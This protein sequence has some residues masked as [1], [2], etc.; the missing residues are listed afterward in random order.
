MSTLGDCPACG[1]GSRTEVPIAMDLA[2]KG[3]APF[4]HLVR[5]QIATQPITKIPTAQ[6][7][8]G[9]RKTIV[10]SDGRQKAA[11]LARD[12]PREI[13]L[14]VF[15]QILFISAESLRSTNNEPRLNEDIYTAFL[16]CLLSHNLRFFD[17]DDRHHIEQHLKD[18]NSFYDN[19]LS[20]AL[21]DHLQAPPSF[22]S[23]LLKQLGTPFYSISALSLGYVSPCRTASKRLHSEINDLNKD[24]LDA[25]AVIWIQR[26]LAN[27]AFGKDLADGVR[28]KASRYPVRAITAKDGFSK[29]QREFLTKKGVNVDILV[30]RL[31]HN[32]CESKPDGSIY[33]RPSHVILRPALKDR[34]AQCEHCKTI[35]PLPILGHCPNCTHPGIDLV[36]PDATSYL[37]ARKGFWRDPVAQA[38]LGNE[39]PMSIDVQ[40][41][42]AQLSYKDHNTPSPTTEV[43]ERQF[44]DI[45]REGE[46]SI[47]VLSCTT[48]MEVGIDIGSLIAVSMRNVPPMRQNYQQRAGRAGRR[49]AAVS[50]VLTYAQS[51]AHD[52]FYFLNPERMLGGD[53]PRPVLDTENTR[54]A[55]RHLLAQLLQDFF[56]PLA[57]S[58][59]AHDIYSALGDSWNFF[60]EENDPASFSSFKNWVRG[61]H[62]GKD[63]LQRAQNWLPV[64][65][66]S[67]LVAESMLAAIEARTPA[68]REG[69]ESS[70]I[71][72]L[73]AHGLLPSYAFPTDLCSLQ[74]QEKAAGTRSG[75]RVAEQAQQSL[76]V[77]LSEYAPGR[78]VVVNKKTYRV[79]TVTASCPDTEINRAAAL[80][81]RA[82]VYRHCTQCSFTAGFITSDDGETK[83][84]QCASDSLSTMTLIR[85][86]T[87]FPRGK[88]EINEF[89]DDQ[90][91]S[92]VTKAQLPLPNEDLRLE[93]NPFG[94]KAGLVARRQQKLIVVNEGDPHSSSQEVGFRVC[95]LCGKVLAEGEQETAHFRDYYFQN[96]GQKAA[97]RCDGQFQRV[98]LGY[99]FTSDILLLRVTLNKPLRFDLLSRR[100]RT[101][102][103]DALQ[104]LCEAITLSIGRVLDIDSREV[105]AGYRFGNDGMS[106]FADIFIYDTLSGGAGYA[107]QAKK[108]FLEIFDKSKKLLE[109]CSCETSCENCLRHYGNR[110]SH[111]KLDRQLG[112]DL[113]QYISSGEVPKELTTVEQQ[114]VLAPLLE[115]VKLAGWDYNLSNSG[116]TVVNHGKHFIIDA[117][118]SLRVAPEFN[119]GK[120]K[121]L[122]FTPYEI[123]RDL[124]SAF[125]ELT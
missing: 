27:F 98:F 102:I 24:D 94:A 48:T 109:E 119:K 8:N 88:R 125:A 123:S 65:A 37:R 76:N 58:S 117:C 26:L 16:K 110:F 55:D 82:R 81:N 67:N 122:T 22:W 74:I 21:K 23:I 89:D 43:F 18:F 75:F 52:S 46:R 42:S 50:T 108:Y 115:M 38:V 56:R 80:F 44:R 61:S 104:T 32:L 45:L 40:E 103:E 72:F 33:L 15:R 120:G 11:R 60:H 121:M 112:L 93:T 107:L 91:F 87:V 90:V 95:N 99:D 31:A 2:T 68:I 78:L 30:E 124:P 71:E 49:G 100:Y 29:L 106:D 84:P 6:V 92:Q 5:A 63:S 10:F 39:P 25:A 101:P 4:A 77:A 12:I 83:C 86:E 53:P 62:D 35:S 70:L 7:P 73:F 64:G 41:H 51:E 111:S 105:S 118:P 114:I 14:D 113:A 17:G 28:A 13:E 59:K 69:L 9:G 1:Q 34:W 97:Q 85:P 54:I 79:G 47:D 66:D 96:G 20:L 36:D 57:G 3:E 19:E 116:I